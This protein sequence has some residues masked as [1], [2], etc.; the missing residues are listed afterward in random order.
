MQFS[1]HDINMDE[2]IN[3][4]E[5]E[6]NRVQANNRS[7]TQIFNHCL[8][9][10]IAEQYLLEHGFEDCDLKYHDVIDENGD[11]TEVKTSWSIDKLQEQYTRIK[12]AT[13][14]NSTRF[15][16]FLIKN[17]VYTLAIDEK[18]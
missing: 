4:S 9:G 7:K 17:G 6:A 15:M 5:A 1:K 2:A 12:F 8:Q 11:I 16:G 13:W 3:R 18:L 10:H 14:N